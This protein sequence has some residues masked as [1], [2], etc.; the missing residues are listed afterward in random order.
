MLAFIA[1]GD[2]APFNRNTT[3]SRMRRG[4]QAPNPKPL[5]TSYNTCNV[6]FKG[7]GSAG[8]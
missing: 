1:I 6:K 8:F 7:V 4:K 5:I 2:D 3:Q